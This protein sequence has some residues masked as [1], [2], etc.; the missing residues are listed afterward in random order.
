MEKIV[1]CVPNFSEGRRPAVVEQIVSAIESVS[2]VVVID[3]QMDPDHN[4]SVITFVGEPDAVAEAAF[5][6]TRKAAELIDLNEHQGVHPRIGAT[7]VIPFVPIREVTMDE[8]IELARR[9]GRRIAEELSIPVYLYERAAT[10]PEREDLASI[11]RGE[12]EGLRQAIQTDADRAPDFGP[13]RLHP[14]A[15]ATAVG[16]RAP[17]IAFNV[18]LRTTDV[19]VARAIAKA[20]R[21]RDGGLRYVKAL[22][23][24]LKER[25]LVQVSMNLVN[26]EA[27]PLFQAFEFVK[28]EADYYGVTVLES[29]IVGLVPQAALDACAARHLQL[30][31][32]HRD[33]VLENRLQAALSRQSK[34]ADRRSDVSASLKRF[35]DRLG[36][37][38]SAPDWSG[39][40][41]ISGMLAAALGHLVAR[42]TSTGGASG[43]GTE[44]R[45]S[46]L[47]RLERIQRALVDSIN[48]G[49]AHGHDRAA[50]DRPGSSPREGIGDRAERPIVTRSLDMADGMVEVL[51]LLGKM[52]EAG[53]PWAPGIALAAQL[54][55]AGVKG[56]C[57]DLIARSE[58]IADETLSQQIYARALTLIEQAE[59]VAA[60]IESRF[61][62]HGVD[63]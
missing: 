41:A 16:A 25:G 43:A 28:R 27:T 30:R 10:R 2:D 38:T 29:E 3:R 52:M 4:R 63:R 19:N 49:A 58:E 11:R 39:A 14:T 56:A 59:E 62:Q 57:F 54:A 6:A 55:L 61:F 18:N 50:G 7:D 60:E 45:Q 48:D 31:R 46:V 36:E 9:V 13:R 34:A 8:C 24:E 53:A 15:G 35:V 23:F 20:V 32:F 1:E 44:E 37:G 17:L 5:R 12:F 33:Q 26:Y 42:L 47:D 22:G 21:G 51:R 40:A